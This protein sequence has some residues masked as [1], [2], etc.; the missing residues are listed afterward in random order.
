[1]LSLRVELSSDLYDDLNKYKLCFIEDNIAYFTTQKLSKQ[2]GMNWTGTSYSHA[3]PPNEPKQTGS[4]AGFQMP[5]WGI[6]KLYYDADLEYQLPQ[7]RPDCEMQY[8]VKDINVR[9]MAAW[10]TGDD[11][12]IYAGVTPKDFVDFLL[13][14]EVKSTIPK[15]RYGV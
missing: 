3:G 15:I 9:D 10:I 6:L 2:K 1:M 7:E 5:K 11:L 13:A 8:S 14:N 12:Q 4:F